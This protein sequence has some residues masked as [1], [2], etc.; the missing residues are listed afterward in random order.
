MTSNSELSRCDL[1]FFSLDTSSY[2]YL[3]WNSRIWYHLK[4]WRFHCKFLLQVIDENIDW[5]QSSHWFMGNLLVIL[6]HT[7]K[8]THFPSFKI[9]SNQK[10]SLS[11]YNL[12][13][14]LNLIQRLA[15]DFFKVQIYHA[16]P[17]S[18]IDLLFKSSSSTTR[19]LVVISF[20]RSHSDS[21]LT[22]YV[23]PSFHDFSD[24]IFYYWLCQMDT[25]E[26][27]QVHLSVVLRIPPI[28]LP[29]PVSYIGDLPVLWHSR[30]LWW[31]T[32]ASAST[33]SHLG[34]FRTLWWMLGSPGDTLRV[35]LL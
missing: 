35:N 16:Y 1:E 20:Y 12:L 5:N 18:L 4:T 21:F 26:R 13:S 32:L 33:T 9:I 31:Q 34:S 8:W 2:N 17:T 30:S 22:D 6:F 24:F 25:R 27:S 7:E 23:Y 3:H 14:V 19:F 11:C 15:K 28:A 29:I 10:K